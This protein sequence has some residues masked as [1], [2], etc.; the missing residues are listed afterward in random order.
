LQISRDRY[1]ILISLA[2]E[3]P[4]ILECHHLAG[5]EAFLIKVTASSVEHLE[6]VLTRL[7]EFGDTNTSIVLSSPITKPGPAPLPVNNDD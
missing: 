5:A 3:M 4:E 2:G 6:Q 7:S 1:P